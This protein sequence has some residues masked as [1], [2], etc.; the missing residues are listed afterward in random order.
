[1]ESP[2]SP[3]L[4]LV[5]SRE[6]RPPDLSLRSEADLDELTVASLPTLL[7]GDTKSSLVLIVL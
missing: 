7:R 4:D 1:M 5:L 6:K 3:T 2:R